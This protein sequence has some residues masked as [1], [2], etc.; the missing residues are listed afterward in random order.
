MTIGHWHGRADRALRAASTAMRQQPPESAADIN[1]VVNARSAVYAQLIRAT[2][3]LAGGRP[4]VEGLD[5]AG[6]RALMT[7]RGQR[8]TQ[9]YAG[10]RAAALVDRQFPPS[11]RRVSA[12]PARSLRRAADAVGVI[13]DILACHVP[14][15]Q[16]PP[17]PEG[18]AIRRGGGVSSGLADVAR[19]TS[20]LV[21]LD[22]AL[23]GWLDHGQG[24]LTE[25]YRPVAEAA[26][27]TANSG[28]AR[29]A[30][31]LVVAGKGQPSLHGLDVA[32]SPLDPAPD[33]RT[34]D[35][36]VA[37]VAAARSW[38]WQYPQ[39]VAGVHLQLG[40]QLGLAVHVATSDGAP[41]KVDGWRRAAIAAAE[42][43]ATPPVG[44]ARDAAGELAEALR[45]TR[46][47]LTDGSDGNNRE[48]MRLNAELPFLA[49]TLHRGLSA[50]VRRGDLFI[51]AEGTLTRPAGSL[52][53]RAVERWRPARSHDDLVQDL[54]RGLLERRDLENAGDLARAA[55]RAFPRPPRPRSPNDQPSNPPTVE[56]TPSRGRG[57]SR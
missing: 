7:R 3:L 21:V 30:R 33:I 9:F 55:A 40:T 18:F 26:R 4:A 31:A 35:D 42:L 6:A 1:A 20:G 10:L 48:L 8:L 16:R 52:V 27:W 15:G 5:R 13:G 50:A 54:G 14:P 44:P 53:F 37:A 51:K 34:V 32:R 45:W 57:H 36:A 38:L 11:G 17:T 22:M 23:P 39:Q 28:L 12:E 29:T 41:T 19:L 25:I 43:R 2:E 47:H 24:H 49:A 56:A 46:S